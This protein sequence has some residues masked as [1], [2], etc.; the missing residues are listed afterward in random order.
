MDVARHLNQRDGRWS[1]VA[2]I[3][4]T[5]KE[6]EH[7][8][9]AVFKFDEILRSFPAGGV[10][11]AIANG[12]PLVRK[13]LRQ[14]LESAGIPLATVIDSIAVVSTTARIGAGC[15]IFP[16]CYVSS[17]AVLGANVSMVSG[18]MVGYDVVL[19]EDSVV[20]GHVNIGG[21][22][23]IGDCVFIGTGTQIK[24]QLTIGRSTIVGMGSVVY[25]NLPESVIAL[26]N[27]CRPIRDN[28]DGKVF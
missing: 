15:V 21:A 4:D 9:V 8:G 18:S 23:T 12:E 20:S 25:K 2:F 16:S 24:N 10:E 11:V 28:I 27:P 5:L 17:Q 3:D 26:G 14:K 19:G 1:R 7:Y 13:T 6:R 22:C